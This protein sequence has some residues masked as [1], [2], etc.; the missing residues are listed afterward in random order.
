MHLEDWGSETPQESAIT[1]EAKN[2]L[3][4]AIS[5]FMKGDRPWT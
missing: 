1:V 4:E 2:D 5:I 3:Y